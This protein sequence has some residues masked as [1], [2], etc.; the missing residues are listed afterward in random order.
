MSMEVNPASEAS[1]LDEVIILARRSGAPMWTITRGDST[2]ILV[3]AIRA[4][5]RDVTWRPDALEEAAARADQILLPQE[6]RASITDILRVIWRARTIARMPEGTTTATWLSP[7]Y[8]AR[9]EALMAGERDQAWRT[10]SLL[11][12]GF[13]ALLLRKAA[14]PS[15]APAD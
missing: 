2:L 5:P 14:R 12:T 9:L 10:K 15:P 6:G 4:I 13:G 7:D 11:F 3:G 1:E 8:Q